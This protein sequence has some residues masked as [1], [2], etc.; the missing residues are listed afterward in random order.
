MMT[1]LG[2]ESSEDLSVLRTDIQS[3]LGEMAVMDETPE[4]PQPEPEQDGPE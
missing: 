4:V 1:M 2:E 3:M